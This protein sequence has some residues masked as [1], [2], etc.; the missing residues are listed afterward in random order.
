MTGGLNA[1]DQDNLA[2]YRSHLLKHVETAARRP[3]H[4]AAHP[5]HLFINEQRVGE[6][7]GTG[8]AATL[9]VQHATRIH[10]VQI[11]SE[12]GILLGGLCAPEHGF[13]TA[14]IALGRE[15][16]DLDVRTH[17]EGGTVHA[18]FSPA[19][20]LW[21]R[22][23]GFLGGRAQDRAW[24]PAPAYLPGMRTMALTQALVA[25]V[26]VGVATDRWAGWTAPDRTPPALTPAQAPWVAPLAE[27]EK[28]EHRLTD[29]MHMQTK[30]IDA[31][32]TQQQTMTQLQRTIA[33]LSAAQETVASGVVTVQREIEKREKGVGREV[34]RMS[35]LL[36]SRAQNAQEELQ[37]EI[38]S[39]TIANDRLSKER[40][41]LERSNQ[42]LKQRLKAAGIDIS[43][44]TPSKAGSEDLAQRKDEPPTTQIA[45]GRRPQGAQPLLFWVTFQ[46]GTSEDS[47]ERLVR[48]V[49][50]RKGSVADGWQAVEIVHPVE[51]PDRFLD[52]IRQAKIVKAVRTVEAW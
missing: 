43:K 11:R 6:L 1:M 10:T 39:L 26:L 36:I 29:L 50:G 17:A 18:V 8:R 7:D 45:E 5:L 51:S 15:A 22:V 20:P 12:D 14:H 30:A 38:H 34:D 3:G 35:R 41:D 40:L 9:H 52:K 27:V 44:V 48:E 28:L 47:I 46:E 37:A 42:E 31:M 32:Q 16:I 23:R 2:D 24:Q 33:K 4:R 25:L 21:D 49:H 13:K 19:A